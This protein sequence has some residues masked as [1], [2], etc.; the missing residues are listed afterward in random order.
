MCSSSVGRHVD[1]GGHGPAACPLLSPVSFA[2][3]GTWCC[4]GAALRTHHPLPMTLGAT[5]ACPA[6]HVATT[7]LGG[8]LLPSPPCACATYP[9]PWPHTLP[10]GVWGLARHIPRMSLSACP[11]VTPP[12]WLSG[13][14]CWGRAALSCF[15]PLQS[16]SAGAPQCEAISMENVCKAA[17]PCARRVQLEAGSR[18]GAEAVKGEE[19]S[20]QP[21]LRGRAGE[22]KPKRAAGALTPS[23]ASAGAPHSLPIP[24][25][26]SLGCSRHPQGPLC[27][28]HLLVP[29]AVPW[30]PW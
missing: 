11:S 16:G 24:A 7:K 25:S 4:S 22:Q 30:W 14:A 21:G 8:I 26:S 1:R 3:Q 6:S 10:A 12:W 28:W 19:V 18:L 2:S 15:W 20:L 23:L 17:V 29:D 13:G 9:M 27:P 5:P